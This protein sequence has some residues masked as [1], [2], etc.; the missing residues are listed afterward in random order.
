MAVFLGLESGE[1]EKQFCNRRHALFLPKQARPKTIFCIIFKKISQAQQAKE[2]NHKQE[3]HVLHNAYNK[4]H[5]TLASSSTK[6]H[7]S[8]SM[9]VTK[10]ALPP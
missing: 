10:K 9:T 5:Y 6:K 8:T 3:R 7:C 1:S 2:Y 4:S